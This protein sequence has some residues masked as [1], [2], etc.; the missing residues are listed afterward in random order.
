MVASSRLRDVIEGAPNGFSYGHTFSGNPLGCA[1]GSAV[2]DTIQNEGLVEAA[3]TRGARLRER[4]DELQTRHPIVHSLRGRGLLQGIELRA[5]DGE[6]FAASARVCG[7]VAG[8]AKTNGLMIY[9]CPTPVGTEHMDALMLAPPLV[10]SDAE[11]D[12]TASRLDAA[13]TRV[14]STL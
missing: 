14:E 10:I 1:V 8:E 11:I 5:P 12:E 3:E 2:I 9:S 4:L 7:R 6:R 13:L